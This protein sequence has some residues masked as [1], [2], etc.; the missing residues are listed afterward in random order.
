MGSQR[1]YFKNL[2]VVRFFAAFSI[3]VAHGFEAWKTYY[4]EFPRGSEVA[5]EM[6]G[7]GIGKL[8]E[9]FMYNLN[10]GVDVFFL[11]SG[12]LITYLLILEKDKT[13]RISLPKFYMRRTLRIWPLYFLIIALAPLIVDWVNY[14]APDYLP[15]VLFVGNFHQLITEQFQFPFAHYWSIAI[16]EQFYIVWPLLLL[17]I[18]KKAWMWVFGV[19]LAISVGTRLYFFV[20]QAPWM[21]QYLHTLTRMDVLVLGAV[22][23]L[24]YAK[25]SFKVR[26]LPVIVKLVSW[27][28]ILV[29]LCLFE[30]AS[31]DSW[32]NASVKK[33]VFLFPIAYLMADYIFN[34]RDQERS[35]LHKVTG[36]FGKVSYGIY[37]FHN[38]VVVIVIK[39]VLLNN[40]LDETWQFIV[41]YIAACLLVA[42]ISFEGYEK[43]FLKLKEKFSV[44]LSRRY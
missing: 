9:Q 27:M 40:H 6:F 23:A 10:I 14:P 39:K 28:L 13:G 4:V 43:W 25:G 34:A 31:Y 41:V 20:E 7:S 17:L 37:M 29:A 3:V 38:F 15:H 35:L 19:L 30:Y 21:K 36:Y 5:K 2:D 8:V 22:S 24:Y 42:I 18:P 26:R 44:I 12:F 11:I 32:F 1:M 16:E 33:Y